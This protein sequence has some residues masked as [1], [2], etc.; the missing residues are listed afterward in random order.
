M[1]PVNDKY[2][3]GFGY[4]EE[5]PIELQKSLGINKHKG[6]DY[7]TIKGIKVISPVNGILT[8][9]GEKALMGKYIII[10]FE[11]MKKKFRFTAMHLSKVLIENVSPVMKVK[12]EQ[13]IALTGDTGTFYN[14]R[15]H[16]HC[17]CQIDKWDEKEMKWVD[18]NPSFVF[19]KV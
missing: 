17:H 4:G 9:I 15:K 7:Y 13:V 8:E 3:I 18:V 11:S 19:G 10:G 12:K 6:V 14:G 1:R 2:K 5:Y 16:P